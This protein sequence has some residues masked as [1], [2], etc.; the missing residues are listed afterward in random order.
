MADARHARHLMQGLPK[1]KPATKEGIPWSASKRFM[2][3]ALWMWVDT[4]TGVH[5]VFHRNGNAA[6]FTP[7]LD[8]DGKPVVTP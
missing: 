7:L 6:G 8:K 4:E 3:K 5:Y 1:D 2:S